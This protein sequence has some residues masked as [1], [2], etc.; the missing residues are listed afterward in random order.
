MQSVQ[1]AEMRLC[2][3]PSD[4]LNFAPGTCHRHT[5]RAQMTDHPN[6]MN[7]RGG[8]P[9]RDTFTLNGGTI[10]LAFSRQPIRCAILRGDR[11]PPS[12]P[13]AKMEEPADAIKSYATILCRLG[14]TLDDAA[15]E[16]VKFERVAADIG[17]EVDAIEK[18][19]EGPLSPASSRPVNIRAGSHTKNLFNPFPH[20]RRV[21]V[22]AGPVFDIYCALIHEHA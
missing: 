2:E 3:N 16:R 12:R 13:S 4:P 8:P 6:S 15:D 14:Q 22:D 18:L 17:R 9:G 7:P 5:R 10:W 11:V 20:D 1:A 19:R 21:G